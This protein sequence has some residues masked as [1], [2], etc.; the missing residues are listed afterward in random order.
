MGDL[1][2]F[3]LRQPSA[4]EAARFPTG[5]APRLVEAGPGFS[6][7]VDQRF[8]A[9]SRHVYTLALV[10]GAIGHPGRPQEAHA[11]RRC[12]ISTSGSPKMMPS[13]TG[14]ASHNSPHAWSKTMDLLLVQRTQSNQP[15]KTVK[16]MRM[17]LGQAPRQNKRARRVRSD[18]ESFRRK[19]VRAS[20]ARW[21]TT[22]RPGKSANRPC[23]L[24]RNAVLSQ[25]VQ[26]IEGRT[27]HQGHQ[28]WDGK[29]CPASSP[30][31]QH[32]TAIRSLVW[33]MPSASGRAM[34]AVHNSRTLAWLQPHRPVIAS[35]WQ[36]D[37]E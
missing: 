35:H 11:N 28:S 30:A 23:K 5:R 33:P 9:R 6:T 2:T 16:W 29:T 17:G 27:Q 24:R 8:D 34:I 3:H 7:S 22:I 25:V 14:R 12:G 18:L 1:D 10:S 15:Q 36:L 31:V 26:S 19:W 20:T 32:K 13:S 21:S 4:K 37:V